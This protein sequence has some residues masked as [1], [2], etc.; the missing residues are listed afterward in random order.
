MHEPRLVLLDEP[1]VGV[2]PQSRAHLFEEIRRLHRAGTTI[3]YISHYIEEVQTLCSRIGIIDQGHLIACD[4]LSALLQLL[5]AVI[6]FRVTEVTPSC[7]K[8]DIPIAMDRIRRRPHIASLPRRDGHIAEA[9]LRTNANASRP[10]EHRNCRTKLGTSVP[11]SHR[12][13]RHGLNLPMAIWTLAKKDFR[14]VWARIAVAGRADA[15]AAA[16]DPRAGAFAGRRIRPKAATT[17][18]EFSIVDLD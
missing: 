14:V 9:D 8:H 17:G 15:H 11:P 2:D 13:L 3:L 6:H 4:T 7:A 5:E 18:C 12:E 1:A 16:V 10:V